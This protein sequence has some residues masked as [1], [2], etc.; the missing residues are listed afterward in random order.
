MSADIATLLPFHPMPLDDELA[1]LTL[2]LEE[3][4]FAAES[5]KGKHRMH[6]PPNFQVAFASF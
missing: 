2:Q 4:G 5:G 3:L 1:A 6:Q